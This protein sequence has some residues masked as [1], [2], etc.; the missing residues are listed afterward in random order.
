MHT[1]FLIFLFQ[2]ITAHN[3]LE[4][5]K[6]IILFVMKKGKEY[7]HF[8]ITGTT[9]NVGL[10]IMVKREYLTRKF[11]IYRQHISKL[12]VIG[13]PKSTVMASI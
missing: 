10:Q 11:Y 6:Y 5:A 9:T 4:L 7:T 12:K 2:M 13:Q 1:L 8:Q 3:I